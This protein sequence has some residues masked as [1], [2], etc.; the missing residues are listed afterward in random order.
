MK[1]Y[2]DYSGL[3]LFK[4]NLDKLYLSNSKALSDF[5]TKEDADKKYMPLTNSTSSNQGASLSISQNG[6]FNNYGDSG[7][8]FNAIRDV[9]KQNK[10][11]LITGSGFPLDAASFGVKDNGT[12][13]F[14]HKKYDTF[15]KETGAYTGAKN[16]AVLIFSGRSGLMYAKNTGSANDVT[17]AMY[18]YVGIIDS[19]DDK[20]KVYSSAQSDA[21]VD[22][23]NTVN[24]NASENT[25]AQIN[26]L[27][28]RIENLEQNN[29]ELNI[30]LQ[31][32]MSKL[33][34]EFT[35]EELEG[36]E[37]SINLFNIDEI[38]QLQLEKKNMFNNLANNINQAI[39][40]TTIDYSKFSNEVSNDIV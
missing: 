15:N 12:T 7:Q 21:I 34:L 20:Q 9:S 2:L 32:I 19:P 39:F 40:N 8:A 36:L 13:A 27:K 16:T 23:I 14:S 38:E 28:S 10:Y 5:L 11:Q 1:K 29:R 3:I 24:N 6:S 18:K 37:Q 30:K 26:S 25:D 17:E 4:S 22:T 35:D 33:N 31:L